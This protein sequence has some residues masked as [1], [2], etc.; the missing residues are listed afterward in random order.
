MEF[1]SLISYKIDSDLEKNDYNYFFTLLSNRF[2]LI[3]KRLA[4]LLEIKY[5]KKFK[6]IYILQAQ[7]NKFF[8]K[9][10]Y[11][12]LNKRSK[13]LKVKSKILNLIYLQDA[14]DLNVEFVNSSFVK[15][16]IKKIVKKQDKLFLI[17]FT[18]FGLENINKKIMNIGPNAT[19]VA[20]YENKIEQIK[21]FKKL[22]L[23]VNETKIYKDVN[24]LLKNKKLI[25]P[26]YLSP[27][28]TSGG[29]ESGSI[30]KREDIIKLKDKFR[31]CN[32]KD[33]IF[34]ARFIEKVKLSPNGTAMVVAKNKTVPLFIS[35]QILRN[36]VHLGNIYP[37]KV[38]HKNK[39]EIIDT[40]IKVGNFLSRCGFR[41][42]FGCDF[43][44]DDK[45]DCF[46]VDLNSR[47]QA[48]YL[49]LLLMSKINILD[50]E[51]RLALKENVPDF[52]YD[53]I[54]CKFIWA[55]SK[56]KPY[57]EYVKIAKEF[58]KNSEEAPFLDIGQTFECTYFPKGYIFN[59]GYLGYYITTGKDYNKV[60]NKLKL[61]VNQLTTKSCEN[62]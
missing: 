52:N 59:G 17:S 28:Y 57:E 49:V 31:S 41:G 44:I 3:N 18:S 50:I 19:I 53:D 33:K 1:D 16:I 36:N 47:R 54:Q 10:N 51:L 29:H 48:S 45:D 5:N 55:H 39:K 26:L 7:P 8:R 30:F 40:I 56:I 25:F 23:S 35:D 38:S 9:E 32:K 27:S 22:K 61:R 60:L 42:L 2:E 46:I 21:L 14:E 62:V 34:V 43:I 58:K 15:K 4:D 20:K 13:E 6:P 12:I 24:Q 37:S 11:I